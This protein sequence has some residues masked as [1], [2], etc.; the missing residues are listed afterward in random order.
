M[1]QQN[2]AVM[3]PSNEC[4]LA[5]NCKQNRSELYSAAA[6]C[7]WKSQH[8]SPLQ[9]LT[10][11]EVWKQH[12]YLGDGDLMRKEK[13]SC[14]LKASSTESGASGKGLVCANGFGV[15]KISRCC[16]FLLLSWF[17][18]VVCSADGEVGWRQLFLGVTC[19][20]QNGWCVLVLRNC[21]GRAACN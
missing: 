4:P 13:S 3:T 10:T 17:L 8:F 11:Q 9:Y 20:K 15:R 6:L 7:C 16:H 14:W 2:T 19:C 5:F 21:R 1:V 12:W 18:G